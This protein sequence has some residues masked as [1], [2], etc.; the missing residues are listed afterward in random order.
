MFRSHLYQQLK[1]Q[2]PSDSSNSYSMGAR[3]LWQYTEPSPRAKP[4]DKGGLGC[5]T[6][7]SVEIDGA[8]QTNQVGYTRVIARLLG[9]Y[10]SKPIRVWTWVGSWTRVGL[11]P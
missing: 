8:A 2:N 6:C 9:I 11:L 7:S 4:E 5:S 1:I 10:G 3:D